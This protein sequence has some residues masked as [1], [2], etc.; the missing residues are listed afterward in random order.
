MLLKVLRHFLRPYRR[1]VAL[2]VV[3]QMVQTIAAL[4]LPSLNADII[5][6]GVV[7][8]DTGYIFRTG[9]VMLAITAVQ[10]ASAIAAVYLGARTAMAVGR[11][12]RASVFD[13]VQRF[14][15]AEM[16]R[17]GAPSLITRSTNDVQQVQMVTLLTFTIMVMAPIM[18]VGGVI[19]ALR[20]DVEL[21]GLLVVIIPVLVAVMGFVVVRMR[22][23][24]Q[25]MQERIDRIN[26]VLREQIAGVRVI[27][28]FNRQPTE[29]ERFADANTRLMTTA[30]GVG[31]LMALMFPAVQVIINASSV[32]VVWFGAVRIDAGDMQVGS[33]IAY[34][35]YLMQILMS[36]LMAVMMF[37]MVP[38]AE[39]SAGR[40]REVLATEP[41]I[42]APT[43]PAAL[44]EPSGN[45]TR[46]LVVE[47][48]GATFGYAGAEA[49]VLHDVDLR[50]EPGRTTA[51]IGATG[52][53]KSTLVN[54]V[55]RL[56]DV[57]GGT[58]R[59]GGL[60]VRDLEPGDLR[61]R[62]SLVPQKAYLFGGT[63][64]ST[65]RHGRAGATDEELWEALEAAQARDFVEALPDGLAAPVEQGGT[66]FSGGQRQRLAI[67]R[68]LVRRGDV[69]LFDD[70]FSAL[71]YATDARLRAALPRA[72]GGAT[73]LIVAQRV[74]T[75]RDAHQIV[76]LDDGRIVG[77]GTHHEL[78]ETNETYQEIVLSQL[79]AEEAA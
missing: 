74:A 59:V 67:A 9:G 6:L 34:L 22:P 58:V 79:S 25:Q 68:A 57:T 36:V 60:D 39:V 51:V 65:L 8:G 15:L 76:V 19:M 7:T 56:L 16:G 33:L 69:Y 10:V 11:D 3:L 26:L 48:D 41:Q 5:D 70:S 13:R 38:R 52:S 12:M 30:L 61:E 37:V 55:P 71:D 78:M 40:I 77:T 14:S 75:I 72:T 2:V 66:N 31:R 63:I 50:L 42:V 35:S 73:V 27:R 45:G 62:I 54:L 23:L 29:R 20:Q 46:G 18:M 32:A 1:D 64:A 4:S 21:S 53:G 24:F 43:A 47:L 28:S 17:F 49:P 44:R